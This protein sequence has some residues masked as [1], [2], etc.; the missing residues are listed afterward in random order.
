MKRRLSC[1]TFMSEGKETYMKRT[2]YPLTIWLVVAVATMAAFGAESGALNA[3]EEA[4]A[5]Q[6]RA[7]R[8]EVCKLLSDAQ[9]KSVVPDLAGSMVTSNGE[10]LMKTVEAYECAHVN[11]SAE[12]L[13]VIVNIAADAAS[14]DK[15]KGSTSQYGAAKKLDIGDA[16]WLYPKDGGL[17]V[18]VH[19][20][21]AVIDLQLTTKDA[22]KK[23]AT[24]TELAR[25]VAAKV[26]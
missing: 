12:G 26:N 18:T 17:Y 3:S 5:A 7:Q 22:A 8:I 1:Y 6:G 13:N 14:F 15:I 11:T 4:G 25:A 10:S 23:G 16:S 9:V 19:K 20:G 2:P 21:R 24:L